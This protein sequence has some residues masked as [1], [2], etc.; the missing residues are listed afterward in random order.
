MVAIEKM[1]PVQGIKACVIVLLLSLSTPLAVIADENKPGKLELSGAEHRLIKL[2]KQVHRAH[3]EPFKIANDGREA[4]KRIKKL[5]DNYPDNSKVIKLFD[6]ARKALLA[7]KGE[8]MKITPQ[9]LAY[10]ENEKILTSRFFHEAKMQWENFQAALKQDKGKLTPAFPAPSYKKVALNALKGKYVILE[11]FE[12]PTNMFRNLGRQILFVGSDIKGYYF[13]NLS[14]R[15]WLG[16]YEAV[17]RYRRLI[18]HDVPEGMKWTLVGQITN[19]ERMVPQAGKKKSKS[20]QFGWMIESVAIYVPDRTFAIVDEKL[21]LGG[22]FAGE[23]QIEEIKSAGYSIKAIPDD[24]SP[25]RLVEIYATAIK[26]K[27][28][29]LYLNCIDPNWRKTPTA[30]SRILYHWD[31]HQHRFATFYVH[32]KVNVADITVIK[33]FDPGDDLE[34][35]FLTEK[36]MQNIQKTAEPLVEKASLTTVAYDERGRQYGSPKPRYLKRTQ[37]G[38]WYISN[39]EQP[40]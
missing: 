36:E 32:V 31:W 12:Y 3:G 15:S 11:D 25:E 16:A 26:E 2:E 20:P 28:Y 35:A 14:D 40:F 33:G 27:N 37:K 18:N 5:K 21:D 38:R 30:L 10:R 22:K 34:A 7:S 1:I 9:M 8:V 6:R 23:E 24:V 17:K 19:L 29:P 4:L 13:V 39:Y